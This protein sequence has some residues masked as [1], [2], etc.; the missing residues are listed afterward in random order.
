MVARGEAS[1]IE[2]CGQPGDD[3]H[4]IATTMSIA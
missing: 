1:L 2:R 4:G 3:R